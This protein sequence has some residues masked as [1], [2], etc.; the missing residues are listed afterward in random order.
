MI[1]IFD[2]DLLDAKE[3]YIVHQVNCYGEME[4]GIALQIKNR[5]PDVYRRYQD[6]CNEHPAKNLIGRIL[7]IPTYDGKIIC[8]I[9]GQEK[10]FYGKQFT[11]ISALSRSFK[12]LSKIVPRFET[13]AMPYLIG[14]EKGEASWEII[15]PIIQNIFAKHT[16]VLYKPI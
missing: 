7:L 8:N 3:T 1:K 16:V 12:S 11:N 10:I 13:I 14:C 5:Y 4:Y 6:Y 2:G 15:Y 9:F